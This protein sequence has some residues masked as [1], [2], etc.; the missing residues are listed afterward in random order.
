MKEHGT[1]SLYLLGAI[2]AAAA[3]LELSTHSEPQVHRVHSEVTIS[4]ALTTEPPTLLK[5]IYATLPSSDSIAT[6]GAGLFIGA[7]F[8]LRKL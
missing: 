8:L 1:G 5:R 6:F 3:V 2:A 7:G 4:A